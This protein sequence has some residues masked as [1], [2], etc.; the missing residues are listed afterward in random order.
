MHKTIQHYFEDSY[1]NVVSFFAKEDNMSLS[2][3][4]ELMMDVKRD[5]EK[6]NGKT[7]EKIKKFY[8]LKNVIFLEKNESAGKMVSSETLNPLK[9][10]S[11][12]D[13]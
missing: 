10:H 8:C 13:P 11:Y 12:I 2:E 3:L 5:I 9:K 1:K 4:D 7:E 6:E